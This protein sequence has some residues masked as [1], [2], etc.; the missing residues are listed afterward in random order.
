MKVRRRR[1]FASAL[2]SPR[3][4]RPRLKPARAGRFLIG[5]RGEAAALD[6]S[7]GPGGV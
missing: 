6:W 1:S 3:L 7:A 2:D 4:L 5:R